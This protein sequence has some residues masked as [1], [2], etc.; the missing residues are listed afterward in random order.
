MSS[1]INTGN[2][3]IDS[4]E[5][6]Y[7]LIGNIKRWCTKNNKEFDEGKYRLRNTELLEIKWSSHKKDECRKEWD[8]P[9]WNYVAVSILIRGN[10]QIEFKT[11][12]IIE[13]KILKEEGDY[14]MWS[15]SVPHKWMALEDTI[16][17]TVRW[18]IV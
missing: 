18:P 14:V 7:W 2:A 5:F 10:F 17:I 8:E 13:E 15:S 12:N 16:I 9:S 3:K 6:K 1:K 4:K 11:C